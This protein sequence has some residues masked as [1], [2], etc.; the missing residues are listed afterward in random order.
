MIHTLHVFTAYAA[1]VGIAGYLSL[2]IGGM[3][4]LFSLGMGCA[5][6]VAVACLLGG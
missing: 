5:A 4:F 2:R 1:I 3:S 6:T